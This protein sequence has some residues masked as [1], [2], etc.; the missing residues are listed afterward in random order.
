MAADDRD[1]QYLLRIQDAKLAQRLTNLLRDN[2]GSKPGDAD[3]LL[4]FEGIFFI[5]LL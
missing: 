2:P 1:E 5:M 3:I 4:T